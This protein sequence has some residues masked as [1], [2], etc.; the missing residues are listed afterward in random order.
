MEFSSN[1][2]LF[3]EK[4]GLTQDD[5]AKKLYITRQSISKWENG[6]AEPSIEVLLKLAEIFDI[7]VDELLKSE[8]PKIKDERKISKGTKILMFVNVGIALFTF[9]AS[10]I[11]V[12]M[13]PSTLP[14]QYDF[15]GNVTRHG[16]RWEMVFLGSIPLMIA[17]LQIWFR[18]AIKKTPK[19]HVSGFKIGL[20]VLVF[21]NVLFLAIL[22]SFGFKHAKNLPNDAIIFFV[23]ILNPA[24]IVISIFSHPYFNKQ[25][26]I[27][28]FKTIFTLTNNEAWV[29]INRMQSITGFVAALIAY[30]VNV[31][32]FKEWT[33]YLVGLMII[34]VIPTYIYHEVLRYKHKKTQTQSK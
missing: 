34:S 31:I 20:W 6:T 15:M 32:V 33:I 23:G 12:Q 25:N 2:K 13:L 18:A 1:L 24:L 4:A 19:K 5:L 11:I 26:A 3:R 22:L 27:Y 17:L 10:F 29:K 16:S 21:V 28:G 7:S 9:L 8:Q 14:M 30:L